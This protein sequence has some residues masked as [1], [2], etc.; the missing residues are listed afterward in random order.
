MVVIRFPDTETQ[1]E[2][3]GF[4]AGFFSIYLQRSGE[5]IVPETVLE[6]LASEGFSFT[7]MGRATNAQQMAALRGIVS[8]PVQRRKTRPKKVVRNRASRSR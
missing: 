7:V 6:A 2:A 1:D 3:V 5:V 4:L 8:D